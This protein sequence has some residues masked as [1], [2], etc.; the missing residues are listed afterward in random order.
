MRFDGFLHLL[1]GD[2]IEV[3]EA[4]VFELAA[5][6]AHAEPVRDRPVDLERLLGDLLLAI[7]L[8]VLERAHVV[9]AVGQLDE[10]DAD[11]VHH[12]EHHLAQVFGLLLFLGGEIDLADLGDA[13][14]D[15]RDLLAEFLA[16]VD[17][18]DRGVFDG[19][20][21]QAGG[22]GDRIHLHLGQNQRHFKGMH[23][24]RLTRGAGLAGM[25]LQGIVVG[26]LDDFQIVG[27]PVGLHP[28]HQVA[29]LRDREDVGCDLLAQRR[30]EGL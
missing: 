25:H 9:Q 7:G 27:R 4:Q 22:N 21:Q 16:D 11:V 6:L 10:H 17:D 26:F 14:D 28:L 3:A 8:Q 24:V 15:V 23:Q 1:V 12:G 29:K 13:F 20:V 2:R 19:I 30:H 5:N 18:G